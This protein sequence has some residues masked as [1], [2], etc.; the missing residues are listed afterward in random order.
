M[1][2][3]E[4]QNSLVNEISECRQ[5]ILG[6][7]SGKLIK[8]D[9]SVEYS[10][11]G[12]EELKK[13]LVLGGISADRHIVNSIDRKGWWQP[14]SEQGQCLDV[15]EYCLIGID[16]WA[17]EESSNV[18]T[19]IHADIIEALRHEL[20]IEKFEAII[21]CSYGG[22]VAQSYAACYPKN[23]EQLI[24]VCAAGENSNKA[25]AIRD[26][27][28]KIIALD[29]TSKETLAIARSLALIGY[30]GEEELENK[31]SK[32][33]TV[34]NAKLDTEF[35]NY[36]EKKSKQFVK[37]FSSERYHKLSLSLDLHEDVSHKINAPTLFIAFQSD[38]LV[39]ISLVRKTAKQIKAKVSVDIIETHYGHDAFLIEW[40]KINE[41]IKEFLRNKK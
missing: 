6:Y 4:T 11:Y 2:H 8:A 28:R 1:L 17:P 23:L 22:L 3:Y 32:A 41:S 31:F 34:E 39:P 16:Y 10:V 15:D 20:K 21:G 18:S 27:Q 7:R 36:L 19:K 29:P 35:I 25:V 5:A 24:V 26:I 9:Y 38:Q 33:Q 12:D 30:R 13:V 37:H 14:L 40:E